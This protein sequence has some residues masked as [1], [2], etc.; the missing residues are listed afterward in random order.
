MNEPISCPITGEILESFDD[1]AA[2]LLRIKEQQDRLGDAART[3]KQRVSELAAGDGKT[4]LVRGDRHQA[5]VTEA[6]LSW[7]QPLLKSLFDEMP[8]KYRHEV[9]KISEIGVQLRG[10]KNWLKATGDEEF[11]KWKA[12]LEAACLGVTGS[13]SVKITKLEVPPAF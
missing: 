3:I 10:Y 2:S 12:R 6:D 8:Y 7:S 5:E 11:M 1:Y 4:R 13:P 9:L